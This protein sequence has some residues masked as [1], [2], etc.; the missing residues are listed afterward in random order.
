MI[1][2]IVFV[3]INGFY[4]KCARLPGSLRKSATQ[5]VARG[6]C[7]LDCTREAREWNVEPG[8]PVRLARRRCP[9]L[10]VIEENPNL[11]RELYQQIWDF[12]AAYTP[13]VEPLDHHRGLLDLTGC[14][15]R[16]SN[17]REFITG[18]QWQLQFKTSLEVRWGGGRDRWIAKLAAD[19]N[20]WIPP[21]DEDEF[22]SRTSLQKLEI[23]DELC[24]RLNRFGI[25]SV[26]E[27][28][29]VP[30]SFFQSHL[31]LAEEEIQ[32]LTHRDRTPV[33]A[34][35]P[36]REI[37]IAQDIEG[38][39]ESIP[40]SIR[41]QAR[42]AAKLLDRACLQ[43]TELTLQIRTRE[44]FIESC[45]TSR[46]PLSDASR[47]Q[48]IVTQILER[49][50]ARDPESIRLKLGGLTPRAPIQVNL[51]NRE[52]RFRGSADIER[53][54]SA[55]EQRFGFQILQTGYELSRQCPPRFAQLIL[56]KRGRYLP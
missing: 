38:G 43:C 41:R 51:L 27:L 16:G 52:N 8:I 32:S 14:I 29:E 10:E 44:R 55:L 7:I 42:S 54:R 36:P 3:S 30:K 11:A 12:L 46:Q 31:Q 26:R 25:A 48:G 24:G 50:R 22:L 1:R 33:R 56:R 34:L 53:T 39:E 47:I 19:E 18:I 20:D 21:E 37:E 15:P 23:P 5:A 13:L 40:A 9:G 35:Y 49:E 6:G 17:L 4:L 45:Y 28:L 2:Y